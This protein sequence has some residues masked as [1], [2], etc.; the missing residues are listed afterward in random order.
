MTDVVTHS[1]IVIAF[2]SYKNDK[3]GDPYDA[4]QMHLS[5]YVRDGRVTLSDLI[6]AARNN[7][8]AILTRINASTSGGKRRTNKKRHKKRSTR[9]RR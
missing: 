8:T 9:R 1:A 2:N 4:A 6:S 7:D 5:K 3:G